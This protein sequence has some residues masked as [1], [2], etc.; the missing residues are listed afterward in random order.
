MFQ[1]GYDNIERLYDKKGRGVVIKRTKQ[2]IYSG[3]CFTK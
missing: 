2:R 1:K 3:D